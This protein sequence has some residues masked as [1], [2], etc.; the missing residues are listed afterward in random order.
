MN[1]ARRRRLGA[2]TIAVADDKPTFWDRVEA[3]R[4][5]PG[6]LATLTPLLGPGVVFLDIGAWVGP[7]SLLAA[8]LGARVIAVEADPAARD[9]FERNLAVNPALAE[10][11]ELVAA[12][13]SADADPVR[14]G[15]RRKPGDSMSSVLL[16]S[17][18]TSW[19]ADAVTP[20]MLADRVSGD[21]TI[22]VKIDIE[23]A[24]Y[25]LLPH[26][27][28]LIAR[29]DVSV[30]LSLHPVILAQSG[31]QHPEARAQEAAAIFDGWSAFAVTANGPAERSLA[32][33]HANGLVETDTWLFSSPGRP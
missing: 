24:E 19:S 10:R 11:I 3:G 32:E 31:E 9:Q 4:W 20:A 33:A 7:L 21:E 5:E 2:I 14:L 8:A 12:A 1:P 26:L 30:L 27:G 16:A 17:G 18:D 25:A 29:P 13:I 23:G 28:P 22:V 15:A 6:T